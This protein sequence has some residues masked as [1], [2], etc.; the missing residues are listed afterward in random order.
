M[1]MDILLLSSRVVVPS[2]SAREARLRDD[3][4][5]LVLRTLIDGGAD[6]LVTGEKDLLVLAD[7]YPIVSPRSFLVRHHLAG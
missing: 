2:A 7:T 5:Q 3:T 6:E 4:D 1:A